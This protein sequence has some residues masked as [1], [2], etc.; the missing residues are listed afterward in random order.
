MESEAIRD[1]YFDEELEKLII[2]SRER[3]LL[4]YLEEELLRKIKSKI[5]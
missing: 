1:V 3:N 2:R 4:M 5:Q